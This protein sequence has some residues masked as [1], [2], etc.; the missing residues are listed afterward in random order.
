MRTLNAHNIFFVYPVVRLFSTPEPAF[1]LQRFSAPIIHQ[2]FNFLYISISPCKKARLSYCWRSFFLS[3]VSLINDVK[4][5]IPSCRRP[6]LSV[7]WHFDEMKTIR[8]YLAP[9]IKRTYNDRKKNKKIKY[10]I[11]G[12]F[13]VYTKIFNGN[14][15]LDIGCRPQH[16]GCRFWRRD[17]LGI[18]L[19]SPYY[20]YEKCQICLRHGHEGKN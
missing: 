11:S 16:M 5:L 20:T 3:G 17:G 2:I 7:H 15:A 19:K 6:F 1:R 4:Y 9:M 10:W 18:F 12:W 14:T 13:S 8:I